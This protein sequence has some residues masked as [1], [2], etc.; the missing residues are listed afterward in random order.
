[1]RRLAFILVLMATAA[2]AQMQSAI[3][4][5]TATTGQPGSIQLQALLPGATAYVCT[6]AATSCASP[7]TA[8]LYS[9]YAGT[10]QQAQP[11]VADANGRMLFFWAPGTYTVTIT[12]PTG[13]IGSV[14][15]Y[16]FTVG[17]STTQELSIAP[18]APAAPST[19]SVTNVGTTGSTTY[20]YWVVSKFTLGNS[21]P[22]LAAETTTS[23][24]TLSSYNYNA[25]SWSSVTG[26]N[27]YD[28]LRTSTSTAPTGS[29]NCAVATGVSG[30]SE[31]DQSNSLSSYTVSTYAGNTTFNIT[32]TAVG[33]AE[34]ALN[35]TADHGTKFSIDNIKGVTISG[36]AIEAT[37][38]IS[39]SL[40]YADVRKYGAMCDGT[41][42]DTT[43]LQ[44][45][46]TDSA[47]VP[48]YIPAGCTLKVTSQLTYP[49]GAHV[50][51]GSN[52]NAQAIIEP[53]YTVP[54]STTDVVLGPGS[55]A[56]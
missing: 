35:F 7:G 47:T 6:G 8:T 20:Y 37:N 33:A 30:T 13:S 56:T 18:V 23:A 53:E 52:Q 34:S 29:C 10:S 1:M 48:L 26:A 39:S 36:G 5:A 28:V 2:A 41:T 16:V 11:L 42:D 12:P 25:I 44:T 4:Q 45:G 50:F 3:L 51:G 21:A 43:A 22:S 38:G 15:T 40:A 55:G 49:T 19:V 9:N 14:Q 32:N 46:L 31:N 54:A 17:L 27:T 24:A